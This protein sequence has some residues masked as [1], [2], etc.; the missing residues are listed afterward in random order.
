MSDALVEVFQR[1]LARRRYDCDGAPQ[2]VEASVEEAVIAISLALR[3]ALAYLS[4]LDALLR[5]AEGDGATEACAH[6]DAAR[7]L[8]SGLSGGKGAERLARLLVDHVA[9]SR[10]AQ[11]RGEE[12]DRLGEEID[13]LHDHAS[14]LDDHASTLEERVDTLKA[15]LEGDERQADRTEA[16]ERLRAQL[17]AYLPAARSAWTNREWD[18]WRALEGVQDVA[19]GDGA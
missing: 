2:L 7:A 4:D 5:A 9:V 8:V 13:R 6:L 16:A 17:E 14:T 11:C 12:I 18:L 19:E 1:E 3:A 10:T 15:A